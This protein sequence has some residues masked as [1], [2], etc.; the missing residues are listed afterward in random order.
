MRAMK[1]NN[2]AMT[3]VELLVASTLSALVL[4]SLAAATTTVFDTYKGST[5]EIE[6]KRDFSFSMSEVLKTVRRSESATSKSA[7]SV[8]LQKPSGEQVTYAWSGAAGDPL[9]MQIDAGAALPLIGGVNGFTYQLNDIDIVQVQENAVNT[10]ILDFDYYSTS[11]YWDFGLLDSSS[12]FGVEFEIPASTA[13]ERVELTSVQLRMGKYNAMQSG[14]LKIALLDTRTEDKAGP[15]GGV[16]AERI[17]ANGTLPWLWWDGSK[18]CADFYTFALGSDFVCYPNRRYCLLVRTVDAADAGYIRTRR[19]AFPSSAPLADRDNGIRP[20]VT[21]DFGSY[22]YTNNELL[23]LGNNADELDDSL[24]TSEKSGE[25]IPIIL[26]GDVVTQVETT[27]QK[28]GSVDIT[29]TLEKNGEELTLTSRE[30]LRG[31]IKKL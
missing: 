10:K 8:M 5:T 20:Y 28:T 4:M 7:N 11:Q 16:I 27:V 31:G 25:D 23:D 3:L 2:R 29:V 17:F 14:D 30:H 12:I 9:T 21:F 24:S 22:W 19:L 26:Y 15:F 13:V 1:R 18:W 6:L